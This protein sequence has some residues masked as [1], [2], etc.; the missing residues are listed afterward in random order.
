MQQVTAA[1]MQIESLVVLHSG[2]PPAEQCSGQCSWRRPIVARR[3]NLKGFNL[4][5]CENPV[6]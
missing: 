2:Q 6:A 5:V 3:S 4:T 1:F